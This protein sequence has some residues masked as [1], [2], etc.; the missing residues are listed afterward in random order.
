MIVDLFHNHSHIK[1]CWSIH[2][3]IYLS[4]I[5]L[6]I[7]PF[8]SSIY[9][10]T[11]YLYTICI[12]SISRQWSHIQLDDNSLDQCLSEQSENKIYSFVSSILCFIHWQDIKVGMN[13]YNRLSIHL[14][15]HPYKHLWVYI[16][17]PT[18]LSIQIS[19]YLSVCSYIYLSIYLSIYL[20]IHIS[21]YLIIVESLKFVDGQEKL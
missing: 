2:S 13:I 12:S 21:I 20:C 19:I 5:C 4:A 10:S 14:S 8:S 11:I 15:I 1:Y 7:Y 17:L 3:F 18:N 9:L 16:H 6:S